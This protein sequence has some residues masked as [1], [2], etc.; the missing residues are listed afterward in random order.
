MTAAAPGPTLL[1]I[2]GL[3]GNEPAGVRA[4][5]RIS[6]AVARAGGLRRG[7]LVA[8]VGNLAALEDR[9]RYVDRDLNRGW[10]ARR[11]AGAGAE[12]DAPVE[13][14]EQAELL[15]AIE[16]VLADDPHGVV[17]LDLHTTSSFGPPF[18]LIGDTLANRAFAAGLGLPIVLGLEEL[19]DGT[20][21][22]FLH[23]RVA[24]A[25]G[26]EGGQHD[27]PESADRLEAVVTRAIDELKMSVRRGA[28][29]D[30][31]GAEDM[32]LNGRPRAPRFL[33]VRHR[34]Q[35]DPPA[36]GFRMRAGYLNFQPVGEGEVVADDADGPIRV[37]ERGRLLM[38]LYQKLGEDGFFVVRPIR[39]FWI[40]VSGMLRRRR[41]D[42]WVHLLPGVQ[43]YPQRPATYAVN[44]RVAR[45]F[46]LE[47][48]HLLG[49][50]RARAHGDVLLVT[51]R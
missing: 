3:H 49:Y 35:V 4:L 5:E 22:D 48:F 1:C 18:S 37:P 23:G 47:V 50:R 43:T 33:E 39:P 38:P 14:R 13:D 36:D 15:C 8:M 27:D 45:W 51:R 20:L 30:G 32:R 26:V 41:A 7:R 9:E 11:S 12:G 6:D 19:L 44:R 40:R 17:A 10:H 21:L 2:A 25:V 46:A 31:A 34:R 42:R 28:A 24:V 16:S 29:S